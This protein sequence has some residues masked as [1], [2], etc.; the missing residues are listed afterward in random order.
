M[1]RILFVDDEPN[2][3]SALRRSLRNMREEWEMEFIEGAENALERLK[4]AAFDVIVSDIRMPGMDGV[5]LLKRVKQLYPAMTRLALSGH[6]DLELALESSTI[7]HQFLAKPCEPETLMA[8]I[9]RTVK[10]RNIVNDEAIRSLVGRIESLPSPPSLYFEIVEELESPHSSLDKVASIIEKDVAMTA[11][12]LQLSNSPLFSA[13][14]PATTVLRAIQCLGIDVIKSLTLTYHLFSKADSKTQSAL[15]LP[16]FVQHSISCGLLS[17]HICASMEKDPSLVASA[18]IAGM[19]HDIGILIFSMNLPEEYGRFKQKLA[20]ES[21][22]PCREE[23]EHLGA[24]HAEI[25]AY[26]LGLWGLPDPITEAVL[27]HHDPVGHG[28][29][30]PSPLLSVY[31]ASALLHD[32]CRAGEHL[33]MAYLERLGIAELVPRWQKE[34]QKITGRINQQ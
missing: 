28:G 11:K 16:A 10:I 23:K 1:I 32:Q 9:R 21:S 29:K 19:L 20:E 5:E 17:K 6:A 3:L 22:N 27:F 34:C 18:T 12:I 14:Q 26:L 15:D 24:T 4:H 30:I 13:S 31:V 33:D 25:G 7:I 8:T 2:V